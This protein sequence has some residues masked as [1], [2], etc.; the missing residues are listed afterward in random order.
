MGSNRWPL[1]HV[2]HFCCDGGTSVV[3]IHLLLPEA[4][5][6]AKNLGDEFPRCKFVVCREEDGEPIETH[7]PHAMAAKGAA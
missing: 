4:S 2:R 3:R 7:G 1:C 5:K 6:A